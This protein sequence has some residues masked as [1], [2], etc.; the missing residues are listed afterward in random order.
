MKNKFRIFD[1]NVPIE[2][3]KLRKGETDVTIDKIIHVCCSLTNFCK[4]IVPF[5]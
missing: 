1:G 2:Y 5:D 3:M 4:P